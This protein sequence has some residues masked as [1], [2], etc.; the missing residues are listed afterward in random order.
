MKGLL[1]CVL[2]IVT[3]CT[4]LLLVDPVLLNGLVDVEGDVVVWVKKD[5]GGP[6]LCCQY[7]RG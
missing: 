2:P 1:V 3:T 7:G 6:L 5:Q 4:I